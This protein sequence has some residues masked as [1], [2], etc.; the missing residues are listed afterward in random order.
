MTEKKKNELQIT[1]DNNSV[2]IDG[3][4]YYFSLKKICEFISYRTEK[5]EKEK[6][7]VDSYDF[8]DVTENVKLSSK[9]V[10]EVTTPNDTQF[11]NI[12]YDLIKTF[13]I[14]IITYSDKAKVHLPDDDDFEL[15]VINI[16]YMPVGTRIVFNTL[17]E[18]GI[19][20][21]KETKE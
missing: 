14:Q 3:R 7:V 6:E 5:T 15:P 1:S 4:E 8:D 2:I 17:V 18:E 10:R 16:D 12:K 20:I 21:K 9:I 19:L 13:I 11:D